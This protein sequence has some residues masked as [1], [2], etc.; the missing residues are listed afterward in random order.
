MAWEDAITTLRVEAGDT[1]LRFWVVGPYLA[2]NWAG[3]GVG[4]G[5]CFQVLLLLLWS[6]VVFS[7]IKDPPHWVVVKIRYVT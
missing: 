6:W 7:P 1:K 2:I 3:W 4:D 5:S